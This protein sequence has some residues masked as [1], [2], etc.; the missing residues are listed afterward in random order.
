MYDATQV[1]AQFGRAL[2]NDDFTLA[3]SLLA[4]NATYEIGNGTLEGPEAICD[5]Y[6]QNML[7][8]RRKFDE[9]VWGA[10]RVE[11]IGDASF[12]I[13]YTD[14]LKHQGIAH[15][16]RCKQRI[17]VGSNGKICR[18]Q[19]IEDPAEREAFNAFLSKVG[20]SPTA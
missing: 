17:E 2:D 13:C 20:L 10:S 12:Y 4:D 7:A 8:G 9:L 11:Q 18:I 6:R 16:F 1:V 19:H 15:T 3:S 14:Y 5:S